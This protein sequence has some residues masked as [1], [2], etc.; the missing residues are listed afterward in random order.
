MNSTWIP[1]CNHRHC[2]R[3][4]SPGIWQLTSSTL[5]PLRMASLTIGCKTV[6]LTQSRGTD[7]GRKLVSRFRSCFF[8]L[9]VLICRRHGRCKM[10]AARL[11]AAVGGPDETPYSARSASRITSHIGASKLS[12]TRSS[13]AHYEMRGG[14]KGPNYL[15]QTRS[16]S[17]RHHRRISS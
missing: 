9:P 16:A 4:S 13:V 15:S 7:G 8:S 12:Q 11:E 5:S 1:L 6:H 17:R 2:H 10:S 14:K 3:S